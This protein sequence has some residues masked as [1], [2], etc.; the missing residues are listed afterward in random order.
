[1]GES[2]EEVFEKMAVYSAGSTGRE[3][4]Y[5]ILPL[6]QVTCCAL[7][8]LTLLILKYFEPIEYQKIVDWYQGAIN[9]KI[10][11]PVFREEIIHPENRLTDGE[12]NSE[13]SDAVSDPI[14][15]KKEEHFPELQSI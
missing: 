13:N 14:K 8:V 5:S 4:T 1:M 9:E 11:L 12:E 10:E 15:E 3:K 2:E 6:M 7:I